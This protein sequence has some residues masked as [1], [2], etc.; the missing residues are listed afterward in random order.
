MKK[1]SFIMA[2][3]FLA[4]CGTVISTKKDDFRNSIKTE[5]T[6]LYWAD[7][8]TMGYAEITFVKEFRDRKI[9]PAVL[10]MQ[11]T[12]SPDYGNLGEVAYVK[13]GGKIYPVKFS[14]IGG[15]ID[16]TVVHG[17]SPGTYQ[18]DSDKVFNAKVALTEEI[19]KAILA[20]SVTMVRVTL[21]AK[22]A[23]FKIEDSRLEKVKQFIL[24]Q[25]DGSR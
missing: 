9:F 3:L 6:V 19:E 20:S 8:K 16:A 2:L 11:I 24:F 12:T 10:H 22:D 15:Q 25:P 14:E 23:T 4:G 13:T 18:F 5:M 17:Y 7:P 1:I 21:G